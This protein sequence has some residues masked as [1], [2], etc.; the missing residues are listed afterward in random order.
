MGLWFLHLQSRIDFRI[1]RLKGLCIFK[2]MSPFS[3]LDWE[4]VHDDNDG[5]D[6]DAS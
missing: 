2:S 1:L 6:D 4:L 3:E 5:D